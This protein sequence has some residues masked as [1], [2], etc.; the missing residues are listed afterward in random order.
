[1]GSKCLLVTRVR[2]FKRLPV[3]PARTT[4]FIMSLLLP[5]AEPLSRNREANSLKTEETH[6]DVPDLTYHLS[7]VWQIVSSAH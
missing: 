5:W 1:M 2:G 6:R 7:T 3:P 4:P